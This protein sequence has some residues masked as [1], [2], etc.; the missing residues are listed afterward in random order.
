[1]DGV[2]SRSSRYLGFFAKFYYNWLNFFRSVVKKR[3]KANRF[4]LYTIQ[5]YHAGQIV[6]C[7]LLLKRFDY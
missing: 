1:M 2:I 4:T 5:M 7:M 6:V 3:L